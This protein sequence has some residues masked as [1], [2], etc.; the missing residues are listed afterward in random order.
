M[1]ENDNV[2]I[3]KSKVAGWGF[4]IIRIRQMLGTN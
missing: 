4:L 3:A 2:K 1:L